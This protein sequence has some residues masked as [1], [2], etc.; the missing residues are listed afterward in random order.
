[1][2][3]ECVFLWLWGGGPPPS[4][5]SSSSGLSVATV[6]VDVVVVVGVSATSP[7]FRSPAAMGYYSVGS[8]VGV[9]LPPPGGLSV[10][11]MMATNVGAV[12]VPS[13]APNG[14]GKGV[15]LMGA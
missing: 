3:V 11:G 8:P 12:I 4:L 2:S 13:A 6:S 7:G 14:L 15:A 10:T 5:S 1:M 9:G